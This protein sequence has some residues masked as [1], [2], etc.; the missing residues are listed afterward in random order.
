M[1]KVFKMNFEHQ[2]M[3]KIYIITIISFEPKVQFW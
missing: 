2:I 1:Y 3:N